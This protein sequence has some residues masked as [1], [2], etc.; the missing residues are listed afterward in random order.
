VRG[1]FHDIRVRYF[2]LRQ[3]SFF[4]IAQRACYRVC[5]L[6]FGVC[7]LPISA[8][9]HF[10]SFRHA[11][12]VID[13]IG[14]LALEPDCIIK[15]RL[16]GHIS[17]HRFFIT[18]AA[19]SAANDYLLDKWKSHFIVVTNPV[20]CFLITSLSELGLMRLQVRHYARRNDG[21]HG[22]FRVFSEWGVREPVL[23]CSE[24]ERL[25]LFEHLGMPR[26]AWYVCV[27]H[28]DGTYLPGDEGVQSYRNASPETLVGAIEVVLK[29]G[30]WVVRVGDSKATPMPI[31]HERFLDYAV[32]LQKS[33]KIDVLLMAFPRFVLGSTSGITVLA[34]VFG[35]PCAI[36]NALPYGGGWYGSKD[37]V[38]PKILR[39][40][41]TG[42]VLAAR[43]IFARGT[44]TYRFA[45]QYDQAGV[46]IEENSAE[47]IEALTYEMFSSLA[48]EIGHSQR[49]GDNFTERFFSVRDCGH[50][51]QA[52]YFIEPL[53]KRGVLEP[54][55][56]NR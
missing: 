42:R 14:H 33:P 22:A 50:G 7:L 34:S 17:S 45:E 13:R 38:L 32:S 54:G 49:G 8:L 11:R 6:F 31:K 40:A 43:E 36:A 53:L 27:H 21:A 23:T 4:W 2:F 25:E 51:S 29:R 30:G 44:S 37:L 16:L 5:L 47:D 26:D 28:R 24:A 52:R 19:G 1:Q 15:E 46:L 18:C 20:Y 41:K 3:Q 12:I 9:L 55:E 10:L 56:L 48:P 35:V 39:D